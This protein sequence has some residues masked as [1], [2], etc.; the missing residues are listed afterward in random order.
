MT[1]AKNIFVKSTISQICGEWPQTLSDVCIDSRLV[2]NNSAFV[3]LRGTLTDGH[4]Y[5]NSAIASGAIAIICEDIPT[6]I[7]PAICYVQV[8][9]AAMAAGEL[10]SFITKNPSAQLKIVGVTGTNGKTTIATLL[11]N[12]FT[13]LGYKCGLLSTIENRIGKSVLKATHTT[14]DQITL[15][16][17]LKQMLEENCEFCFMEVSSHAIDQKRIAGISFT[18]G[19][20][21]N[22]THDHLDYHK[23]YQAYLAAKKAFFDELPATA[24]ALSNVDDKNGKVMLQN[25]VAKKCTYGLKGLCDYKSK[26][27][28]TGFSGLQLTIES[29][30][31]WCRLVGEFNAYNLTAVY[32][33][34]IELKQDPD[35]VLVA[36]SKLATV[37]GRFDFFTSSDQITAIVDYAHTPDALKNVLNT[38]NDIRDGAGRVITVA[39]AGG[40]RD[41]SKRP[42]MAYIA[43]R[44]SDQVI[45]TSDN[46]RSE[47]PETIINMMFDGVDITD[48]KKVL[49]ITNRKEAIRT[50]CTLAQPHDVI[51]I[52]G[53]G[54]EK[55][56]E[57]NGERFP[58]DDKEIAKS[59]LTTEQ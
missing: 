29:K 38:I 26:I 7:D 22:L 44:M 8:N 17:I 12:L 5:I 15:H 27:I 34:A 37:E 24:F 57:I 30:E 16:K 23:T 10:A 33:T 18:G 9:D 31:L 56:Q 35:E 19:I 28:G 32:G 25:T 20:F 59:M 52:A 1:Q 55:Y 45:L 40:D 42:E 46:P 47:D 39:G 2:T 43:A 51:L 53:K 50:A 11:F 4:K 21:T 41:T 36:L 14:P 54:H 58:F 13:D 48:K 3:A 49:K 6:D